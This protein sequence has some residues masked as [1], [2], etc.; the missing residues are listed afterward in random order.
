MVYALVH[1]ATGQDAAQKNVTPAKDGTAPAVAIQPQTAV[2]NEPS[3]GQPPPSASD[4]SAA[5]TAFL[6][7]V[8]IICLLLAIT[9]GIGAYLGFTG[10]ITVYRDY[11]DLFFIALLGIV[12][13]ITLPGIMMVYALT[14]SAI[15][16]MLLLLGLVGVEV[17]LLGRISARTWEDNPRYGAWFAALTTKVFL[18]VLFL[19]HLLSFLNPQDKTGKKRRTTRASAL[20][21]LTLLTP[22][23][24][25]L[26]RNKTGTYNPERLFRRWFH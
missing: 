18:A 11:D 26:V 4:G 3:P 1:V 25:R 2:P 15:V 17:A 12:P 6:G 9:V 24:M 19:T 8:A 5:E 13:T 21:T 23:M 20:V 14:D 16:L 22:V 10:R 7:F